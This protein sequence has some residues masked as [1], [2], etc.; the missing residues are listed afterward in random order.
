MSKKIR[1]RRIEEV[2][3]DT[4]HRMRLAIVDGNMARGAQIKELR[5]TKQVTHEEMCEILWQKYAGD[6]G[7]VRGDYVPTSM[8]SIS[9]AER[10]VIALR[11]RQFF[12]YKAA[13]HEAS[14]S[15]TAKE[16]RRRANKTAGKKVQRRRTA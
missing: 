2:D 12:A 5:T 8:G 11:D 3:A 9:M 7:R 4:E 16:R 1:V 15:K 10:G 14:K 13:I 6:A